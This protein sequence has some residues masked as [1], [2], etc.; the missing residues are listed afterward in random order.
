M[1]EHIRKNVV[2]SRVIFGDEWLKKVICNPENIYS[3]SALLL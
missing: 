2:V 3:E 1:I